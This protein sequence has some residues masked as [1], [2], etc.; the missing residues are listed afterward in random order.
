MTTLHSET[1]P[2]D[3]SLEYNEVTATQML[4]ESPPDTL[5]ASKFGLQYT[6]MP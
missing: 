3:D 2:H 5:N 1:D 6:K 4:S